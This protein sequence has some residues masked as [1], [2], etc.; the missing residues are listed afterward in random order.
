VS[1]LGLVNP[2][3]IVWEMMPYSFIADWF[4]PIGPWIGS[5][6]ADIGYTFKGGSY[7]VISR[8]EEQVVSFTPEDRVA[9]TTRYT[10]IGAPP[11]ML[12]KLFSFKRSCY[13]SSPVPGLYVKSPVSALHF[14]N[15]TALLSLALHG[16]LKELDAY[17]PD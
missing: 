1:Q 8:S 9:G 3:E 4:V 11:K 6:T 13:L 17:V 14:A 15:A 16:K 5:L 7:S 2:A 12:A 10:Y